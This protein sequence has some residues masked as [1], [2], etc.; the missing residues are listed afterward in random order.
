MAAPVKDSSSNGPE[1]RHL[2]HKIRKAGRP[3]GTVV[4]G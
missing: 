2:R 4:K 3:W 1:D